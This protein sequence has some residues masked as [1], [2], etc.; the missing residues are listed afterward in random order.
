MSNVWKMLFF[1]VVFAGLI[2]LVFFTEIPTPRNSCISNL[3]GLEAAKAI[4]ASDHHKQTNDMP[5]WSD[6]IGESNYI[7]TKPVCRAGGT[8]T[9]GAVGQSAWCTIEGH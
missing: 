9:L 1:S 8:Y 6:I 7:H 2:A 5:T 4:W 3:K